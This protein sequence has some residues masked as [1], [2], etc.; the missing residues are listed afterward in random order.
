[1]RQAM[2]PS[3]PSQ[4]CLGSAHDPAGLFTGLDLPKH[5]AVHAEGFDKIV[6]Q[7]V[8]CTLARIEIDQ[9]NKAAIARASPA[10]RQL[11]RAGVFRKNAR[12]VIG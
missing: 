11:E 3:K 12:Q 10:T 5:S 9:G 7:Q 6:S 2:A 1:M 4:S 8:K